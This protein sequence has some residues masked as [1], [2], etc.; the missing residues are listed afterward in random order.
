MKRG[1]IRNPES[2][3]INFWCPRTLVPSIDHGVDL[4]DT[5]RSKFIRQ[6]IREKLGR[7]GIRLAALKKEAA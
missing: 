6:A 3:L 7:H 5:D 1:A 4:T 2:V